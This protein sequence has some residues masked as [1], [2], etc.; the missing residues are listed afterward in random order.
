MVRRLV[1]G[2]DATGLSL[3]ESL[4]DRRGEL[5]VLEPDSNRVEQLRNEKVAAET[6][7]LTDPETLSAIGMDPEVVLVLG[8]D[9]V[10]NEAVAQNARN[11][12]PDAYLV[13]Y[14]GDEPAPNQDWG[15]ERLVDH[16]IDRGGLILDHLDQIHGSGNLLRLNDLRDTLRAMDGELAVFTHD[17][18]DPDAIASAHAL[19]QVA[20]WF[21]V[22]A[23]VYYFGDITHQENRAFVNLLDLELHNIDPEGD[24]TF[25]HLALVDHASPGV[26][27]Q[28]PEETP[29][30]IVIDH[31]PTN[32]PVDASFVDV[33]SAAGATSTLMVDYLE[34]FQVE[35]GTEI[36]TALLYGIRVD[37]R[38]FSRQITTA[39]FEAAATLLPKA[40]VEVLGRVESPSLSPETLDI[41]AR[42]IR[43]RHLNGQIL[44]SCAGPIQLRDALAQSADRLLN[45]EGVT[46]TVVY[47]YRDGTVYVSS[48]SRGV[49]IDLGEVLRRAFSDIGSAGGHETMAGAQISMGIFEAVDEDSETDM[50]EIVED[51]IETRLYEVLDPDR[52]EE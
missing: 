47:G 14:G 37:T 5:F 21:E 23:S 32:V 36:A 3:V 38:D 30:D 34:G 9:P 19:T 7:D 48:R 33:R 28:L 27:N 26:N 18:P 4:A 2:C 25:D 50:T 20:E 43:N 11:V 41:I 45:M 52:I 29:V 46:V 1:L 44:T 24:W 12:F 16:L 10:Q 15:L 6:G 42:A 35:V 49:D 8:A 22:D 17:N 39:D 51:V 40:D 13:A 31:H